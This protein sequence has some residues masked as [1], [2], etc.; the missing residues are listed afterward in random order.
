MDDPD[1]LNELLERIN[2]TEKRNETLRKDI[3]NKKNEIKLIENPKSEEENNKIEDKTKKKPKIPTDEDDKNL[4]ERFLHE[5]KSIKFNSFEI[6]NNIAEY[7]IEYITQEHHNTLYIMGDFTKWELIPM[8]KNKD[9][10]SY[11]IV[12]LKGFKYYY[13]FQSGDQIYIDYNN[14]YE[15][16]PKTLQIQNYIDSVKDNK[17]S[18]P[19]DF[20]NDINILKSAQENYFFSKLNIEDNDEILF[21]EKF[22]RHITSG[23]EIAK[24]KRE[25]YDSLLKSVYSFYDSQFNFIKP[26]E[27]ENKFNNLK[28]Y[29]KNRILAHYY[30]ESKDVQYKYFFK[31]INISENFNFECIKLY[32][33][34]NIKI[35]ARYY[36]DEFRYYTISFEQISTNSIEPNSKLYHI[37]PIEE[38]LKILNDYNNDKVNIL[39]AYFK[40]LT[41]LK[42]NFEQNNTQI[43]INPPNVQNEVNNLIGFRAYA[44]SYGSILVTP[45]RVE[46]SRIKA[47]D[48]EFHYSFNR[49]IRVKNKK[50][51]SF[52]QFEAIDEAVEKAKKPFR[53]RIYYSIKNAKVN[54]I[55]CHVLDKDLRSIKMVIKEID[56]KT[57]P[58]TLKKDEQYIKN[59]ELLLIVLD[60]IPLKL[61]YKGKKVKF[62]AIKIEENKLYLLESPNSDSIFNK[63]YVTVG[64]IGDKIN[65]DLIEQCNEFS[66]SLGEIQNGVDVQVTFDNNK[67]YVVEP[68]MLAVS[69]CLLKKLSSYEENLLNKNRYKDLKD[70]KN[71]NEMDTYFLITQ[72][73]NDYR[74][75]NNK[76]NVD[77]LEQKDKDNVLANLNEFKNSM[78]KVLNY[79]EQ[80]EMWETLEEAANLA[81]EIEDII[82]LFTKV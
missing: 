23:K 51:G 15:E 67:N 27:G 42:N 60:S 13:S 69:P 66:Y 72:K 48:Y 61:Y 3:E 55:H 19:F 82:K 26:Y 22:K 14:V 16:N 35:N 47:T 8:K 17:P 58:H 63:M 37:L 5:L 9:F 29:F 59:N 70:I 76:E 6:E 65:Y 57:D 79:I 11:K 32:D 41:N 54:I 30:I 46:P 52:I 25:E 2:N 10:F 20:E 56:N 18:Q 39:K 64:K 50:E 34:N 80:S 40:T 49:I 31:I 38:S 71:L 81:A 24:K 4:G 28:C 77:K 75:Y 36:L 78:V 74:K 53:F 43:N 62:E 7:T 68:M 21:L 12:L 73:M 33:N 45:N 1:L 44:R